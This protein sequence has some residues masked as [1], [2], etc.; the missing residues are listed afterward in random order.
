MDNE[1]RL[2]TASRSPQLRPTGSLEPGAGGQLSPH[3]LAEIDAKPSTSK[4]LYL[5]HPKL[6]KLPT[7]LSN[8]AEVKDPHMEIE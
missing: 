3:I 1:P 4:D 6:F 7:T 8:I 2:L 5:S